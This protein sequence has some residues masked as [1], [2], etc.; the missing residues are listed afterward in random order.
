V[1][2]R[3]IKEVGLTSR[4]LAAVSD[5]GERLYWRIYQAVDDFGRFHGEP[6]LIR[7]RCLPFMLDRY[8]EADVRAGRDELASIGLLV[9]Y[10]VGADDFIEITKFDQRRR[11][12]KSKFPSPDDG[13]V[14][15][16][17]GRLRASAAV[18]V[19]VVE[20]VG[21]IAL[22]VGKTARDSETCSTP[23]S[24][25]PEPD[26]RPESPAE[27]PRSFAAAPPVAPPQ[28]L[29]PPEPDCQDCFGLLRVLT[30]ALVQFTAPGELV[31]GWIHG[32]H[33]RFGL[34]RC[35]RAVRWKVET[36][37]GKERMYLAPH[38]LFKP[39]NFE[40]TIN[41]VGHQDTPRLIHPRV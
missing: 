24:P 19:G 26:P 31:L 8:S 41:A 32:Q 28:V 34:D 20:D 7:A 38:V 10:R 40:M 33:R 5:W 15:S 29:R 12:E 4:K 11:A 14:L 30:E 36:A 17:D 9:L 22:V 35:Y 23:K 18:V 25:E 39:A 16:L 1:P 2:N 13:V 27:E 3:I 37:R 6:S 21:E